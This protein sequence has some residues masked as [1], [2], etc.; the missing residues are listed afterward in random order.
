[1]SARMNYGIAAE[2][3]APASATSFGS[4]RESKLKLTGMNLALRVSEVWPILWFSALAAGDLLRTRQFPQDV[5]ANGN[6]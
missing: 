6:E 5:R 2:W 4:D 3:P 1:M